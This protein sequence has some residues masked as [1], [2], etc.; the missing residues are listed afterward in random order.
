MRNDEPTPNEK[1]VIGLL[2][3]FGPALLLKFIFALVN[4]AY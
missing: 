2:L 1:V 3:M 4:M